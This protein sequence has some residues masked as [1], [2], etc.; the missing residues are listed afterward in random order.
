MS[1]VTLMDAVRAGRTAELSGILRTMTGPERRA[2]LPELRALRKET[3]NWDWSPPRGGR[4]PRPAVHAAGAACNTGAA[5]AA[6]WIT[7][8]ETRWWQTPDGLLLDVLADRDPAWQTDV[9]HRLAAHSAAEDRYGLISGLVRLA[10]CPVPATEGYVR[11]W[12]DARMGDG[13]RGGTLLARLRTDAELTVLLPLLFEAEGVADRMRWISGADAANSWPHVLA[14]LADEGVL[15]RKILVDCALARLLRGG[16][17]VEYRWFLQVLQALELTEEERRER[18]PDWLALA[19]DAP[20]TVAGHAQKVLGGMALGG[21]LSAYRLAELS[22][23]V[24]FRTEK[25]LSRAQL[26]LVGKVL[27]RDPAQ[28]DEVL[29]TVAEAF[30]HDDSDVRERALK[31][32][33]RHLGSVGPGVREELAGAVGLLGPGLRP[34]AAELFGLPAQAGEP[35]PYEEVLPP[36]PVP[37]RLEA[38]FASVAELAERVGALLASPGTVAES[39]RVLDGLVRHAHRD[40]D[41]LVEAL[42][43]VTARCRW[44]EQS[45]YWAEAFDVAPWGIEAVAASLTGMV[46]RRTLTEAGRR[47][48]S[49]V[50]CAHEALVRAHNERVREAA[51][52][53]R[54]RRVPFLLATPTWSTG[55]LDTGELIDRLGEFARLG[56][57]AAPADFAQALLRLRP[58]PDEEHARR[59]EAL[60]TEEGRRLAAWLT[61][62]GAGRPAEE[63]QV[64]R[65]ARRYWADVTEAVPRPLIGLGGFTELLGPPFPAA[66]HGLGRPVAPFDESHCRHWGESPFPDWAAVL[67][68]H[69]DTVA[70]R[71]LQDVADAAI[72]DS[73]GGAAHLPLLAEGEAEGEGPAGGATHLSVAYGLAARHAEDRIA[74]VDAMLTLAARGQLDPGRLAADLAELAGLGAIRTSRLADAARTAASTGAYATTWEVLRG[75]LPALLS[76]DTPVR[77]AGELLAVAADCVERCGTG[78]AAPVGVPGLEEA[79]GR[80]GS[81][82]LVTQARRLR[83]LLARKNG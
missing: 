33:G 66:F 55:A 21:D 76:G 9:A 75:V 36:V 20:S 65:R 70:A 58:G 57:P 64:G 79:A 37:V 78:Q 50:R 49:G 2:C 4:S 60:G 7:A 23:A 45:V 30:G 18:I 77:G 56:V 39:E 5:A 11:G 73:R 38:P 47:G 19:A 61:T 35:E 29:P 51:L 17:Q 3:R 83:E 54:E 41:A 31:L 27:G 10:G 42:R 1:A 74:S 26:V 72:E 59:A 12:V 63:R 22:R 25:K 81:S 82:Q 6:A 8:S 52:L 62:G 46:R 80:R 69:R 28:A 48:D 68:W 13:C 34:R 71:L 16:S 53:V 24:L 40:R 43:P 32:V 44:G 14:A 15:D 67:P